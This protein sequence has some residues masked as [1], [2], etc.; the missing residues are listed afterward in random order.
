MCRKKMV[1]LFLSFLFF[2]GNLAFGQDPRIPRNLKKI[3]DKSGISKSD[4]DKIV[5]NNS[6]GLV[7]S[8]I[9]E[10]EI[11]P[12]FDE[13]VFDEIE[14]IDVSN[15]EIKTITN[16]SLS[17]N[18]KYTSDSI[19][20]A[21]P[22]ISEIDI[23]NDYFGYSVF[24]GN[25]EVFQNQLDLS[26]DPN[27]VLGFGDD[28][29]VML[30]GETESYNEYK[31]SKDGYIFVK[32][33]GQIFVNGLNIDKIEKKLF[34][35]LK[36]VY[37]TLGDSGG[38]SSTYLDV[39][40]GK[41]SLRPLRV[42]ALGEIKQP[43]AYK[44]KSSA[45]L[46]SSLY[47]FNGP[48]I[49]GSLRDIRLLRNGK[50][51]ASIDYYDYLVSGEQK[52]DVKIQRGDVVFIPP[53]GR[54]IKL[55]GEIN[56]P[57]TFELAENESLEDLIKYAGGLKI[58][59]YTERAQIKRIIPS[60][61]RKKGAGDKMLIDFSLNGKN[62]DLKAIKIFDGD[63]ITFFK[64]TDEVENDVSVEG[65]VFR[66][67]SFGIGEG[68]NVRQLIEKAD[69]LT[70][71]AYRE[72][73][74]IL[75]EYPRLEQIAVNLNVEMADSS[76][77]RTII[78]PG[79]ILKIDFISKLFFRSDF[80]V[81]GH[82]K[83]PGVYQFREG[84][85]VSDLIHLGGGYKDQRW[86]NESFLDR[87]E[88]YRLDP[89]NLN[90]YMIPFSLDSVLKGSGI[91]NLE[92]FRGD[93]IHIY[94]LNSSKGLLD[95]KVR[96]FGYVKK[97][98]EYTFFD[99]MTVYDLLFS[100]G[101]ISD[102]VFMH[103]TY[104]ERADLYRYDKKIN[105]INLISFNIK[106]IQLN[107]NSEDNFLLVPGDQIRVFSKNIFSAKEQVS[108]S[109]F[110][111]LP[112]EYDYKKDMKLSDLF[113][114]AGGV[115]QGY[116]MFKVDVKRKNQLKEFD[117]ISKDF[118]NDISILDKKNQLMILPGDQIFVRVP[119]NELTKSQNFVSIMGEVKYPG[120]YFFKNGTDKISDLI[121]YSGGLTK[122]GYP[123]A[124]KLIR[125]EITVNISFEK[126]ILNAKS[127]S[128]MVLVAGDSIV[129]GKKTNLVLVEGAVRNSGFF[130]YVRGKNID[131]YI[132][133]TGGINRDGS[134]FEIT[135]TYPDGKT[136]IVNPFYFSP[137]VYDGSVIRVGSK[138]ERE[139]FRITEYV[140][141]LT[142][143]YSDL[144]QVTLLI[145]L[146]NSN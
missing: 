72:K 20:V 111:N 32:N 70:D 9:S 49:N 82:F 12:E 116:N 46:F 117:I 146:L 138:E 60:S 83:K 99:G 1:M 68:L 101:G 100:A 107:K 77:T 35:N 114:E 128:N 110:I 47:Y 134:I 141:T 57:L 67:G 122:S 59:T 125:D 84:T 91:A 16:R 43:G 136:K 132:D 109:G 40:L 78:Q 85:T 126:L 7:Q 131:Y 5:K 118:K 21:E 4:I 129:I 31:V 139:P 41:S 25:P 34:K 13:S 22:I 130:Q 92:L 30:W 8:N 121:N 28:I 112:G 123:L 66:P 71:D 76:F 73:A 63:E 143:I 53:R 50:K 102:E 27:Y 140:S 39:T 119:K 69:G 144:M 145:Q 142:G 97:P 2:Y 135:V 127:R 61:E 105:Q 75:R 94:D 55:I 36:K 38:N 51:I 108:V 93:S 90:R 6:N 45:T 124:S 81:S 48:T 115:D 24:Q 65:A 89:D 96:V 133:N 64:I 14:D 29:I 88:L 62:S 87:A 23:L 15:N 95:N 54:T 104:R 19:Q 42:F 56:K 11:M 74:Y 79:D 37:S 3:L 103:D 33:I 113:L 106:N 52:G 120:D 44:V 26:V 58:T 17:E 98:E 86:I 10:E 18:L 137:N 80:S